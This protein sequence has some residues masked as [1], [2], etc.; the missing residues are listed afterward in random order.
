M[1]EIKKLVCEKFEIEIEQIEGSSRKKQIALARQV[2][3]YLARKFGNFSF[4]KIASAF[5]RDDHTTVM[6]AV[7]KIE[8]LRKE[9][10]EINQILLEL[11]SQMNTLLGSLR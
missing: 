5:N 7:N 1:K 3:M 9:N 11:E 6:H 2:A 4:P 10:H 8:N